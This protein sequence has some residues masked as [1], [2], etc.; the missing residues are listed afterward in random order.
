MVSFDEDLID[1]RLYDDNRMIV[2]GIVE[3]SYD[4][5]SPSGAVRTL[6]WIRADRI[7]RTGT[8]EPIVRKGQEVELLYWKDGA[9]QGEY[10]SDYSDTEASTEKA[11]E[12]DKSSSSAEQAWAL[13][14]T[15]DYESAIPFI[16]EAADLGDDGLQYALGFF[17]FYGLGIEPDPE[18][19]V[20]YRSEEHTSALQSRI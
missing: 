20:K 18:E 12:N 15:G 8:H 9:I 17:Y 1:Y 2:Y 7:E 10:G 19:G 6:L 4:Y 13:I 11:E 16:Q 5:E 3:G 14:E